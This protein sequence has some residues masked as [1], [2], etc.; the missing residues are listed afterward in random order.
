MRYSVG[1][2]FF[3]LLSPYFEMFTSSLA[4]SMK[5]S[6]FMAPASTY[7]AFSVAMGQD[8]GN[9]DVGNLGWVTWH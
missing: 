4:Y 6:L 7:G 5:L 2:V 3:S 8:Q 1:I 9:H